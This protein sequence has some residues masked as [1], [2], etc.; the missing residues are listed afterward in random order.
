[1]FLK[2]SLNIVSASIPLA[3]AIALSLNACSDSSTKPETVAE[4]ISISQQIVDTEKQVN[5]IENQLNAEIPRV[6]LRQLVQPP[7]Q[8]VIVNDETPSLEGTGLSPIKQIEDLNPMLD[9]MM[10]RGGTLSYASLGDKNSTPW[11]EV[12]L[13]PPQSIDTNL[14]NFLP[15]PKNTTSEQGGLEKSDLE[16]QYLPILRKYKDSIRVQLETIN[17][18]KAKDQANR[19]EN[20]RTISEFKQKVASQIKIE[21]HF[22][23]TNI[24]D[25][26]GKLQIFFQ[27]PFHMSS[28]PPSQHVV[29]FSDGID[30]FNKKPISL[31]GVNIVL[32]NSSPN[33]GVFE[34]TPHQTFRSFKQAIADLTIQIESEKAK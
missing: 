30:D 27:Q 7:V 18:F 4:P 25:M 10:K 17:A 14:L 21:K 9:L 20:T 8:E 15:R 22:T 6:K 26:A 2:Y 13:L 24:H 32:V 19:A 28:I 29:F 34:G 1:M 12:N 23:K 3:F 16:A 33:A 11:I 31:P 5:E